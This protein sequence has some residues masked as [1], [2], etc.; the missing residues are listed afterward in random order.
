VEI[1]TLTAVTVIVLRMVYFVLVRSEI[2]R[3]FIVEQLVVEVLTLP[4]LENVAKQL[5]EYI[6][7][8][9]MKI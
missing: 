9:I 8:L 2:F 1:W 3:V 5:H 7:D 6:M 4:S